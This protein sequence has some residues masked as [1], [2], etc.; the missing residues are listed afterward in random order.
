MMLLITKFFNEP[1]KLNQSEKKYVT[2]LVPYLSKGVRQRKI[3]VPFGEQGY[4]VIGKYRREKWFRTLQQITLGIMTKSI[5]DI[6]IF[7][8]REGMKAFLERKSLVE[9]PYHSIFYD[10]PIQEMD[11]VL[12]QGVIIIP[13]FDPF[14]IQ[15]NKETKEKALD[16]I[17]SKREENV[18][19][20]K[21]FHEQKDME[22]LKRYNALRKKISIPVEALEIPEVLLGLFDLTY[23]LMM[24]EALDKNKTGEKGLLAFYKSKYYSELPFVDL[25]CTLSAKIKTRN[26]KIRSGDYMDIQHS[27]S[28]MPFSNLFI[29]DRSWSCFLRQQDFHNKYETEIRYI[30]ETDEIH[31]FF[32]SHDITL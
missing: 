19:L 12:D 2:S 14:F 29:T 1:E 27:S 21:S 11:D 32:K 26:E 6:E 7:Q 5:W 9:L 20:K 15:P 28:I 3:I 31:H 17:N 8:I 30:G 16:I 23:D 13:S 4:E 25:E 22:R 24:W 18:K 10:N